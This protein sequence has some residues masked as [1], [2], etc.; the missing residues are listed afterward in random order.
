MEV[1]NS[2]RVTDIENVSH[3]PLL[4]TDFHHLDEFRAITLTLWYIVVL[5]VV[6]GSSGR[7]R[8]RSRR[9]GSNKS[10]VRVVR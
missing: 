5:V 7:S 2:V 6:V 1:K 3:I 4:I 10:S 9:S 8:G